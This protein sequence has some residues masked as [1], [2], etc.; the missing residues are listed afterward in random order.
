[1]GRLKQILPAVIAALSFA[2][3]ISAQEAGALNSSV[4][5][6]LGPV[7][8]AINPAPTMEEAGVTRHSLRVQV[9]LVLRQAGITLSDTS[10]KILYVLPHVMTV[11]TEGGS[12]SGYVYSLSAQLWEDATTMRGGH[13]T[14]VVTWQYPSS[15]GVVPNRADLESAL[16]EIVEGVAREFAN[17]YLRE[18][19]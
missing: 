8:V 14:G 18:N 7:G 2:A 1:M 16:G 5:E 15:L 11:E 10:S 4:L 3:P 19:Q 17:D 9:E 6:D 12:T 13:R